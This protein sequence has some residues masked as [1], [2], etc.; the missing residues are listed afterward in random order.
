MYAYVSG[1]QK[2]NAFH[3]SEDLLERTVKFPTFVIRQRDIWLVLVCEKPPQMGQIDKTVSYGKIENGMRKKEDYTL[4]HDEFAK[5]NNKL[6]LLGNGGFGRVYKIKCATDKKRI[7]A[8]KV[9]NIQEVTHRYML[10]SPMK[11]SSK[12][13]T[14]ARNPEMRNELRQHIL[15]SLLNEVEIM[16][17]L[18]HRNIV[19]IFH[20]YMEGYISHE[21]D[22]IPSS[23]TPKHFNHTLPSPQ[24]LY[25]IMEYSAHGSLLKYIR[26]HPRQCLPELISAGITSQILEGLVYLA[27]LSIVH[28]DIKAANVLLFPHGVIKLC[29]F[30]L[31]FQWDDE[32][33]EDYDDYHHVS[34][35]NSNKQLQKIA[36]NGSAYWLAPEIILHRMATPK[37]DIWS[38]GATVIEMLTGFPPFSNRGPLSACHAV[39]SGAKIDYPR[40]ISEDCKLFLDSCFH[41]NPT[42]RSRA[43]T[44]KNQPWIKH[45]KTNILGFIEMNTDDDDGEGLDDIKLDVL[46]NTHNE[47]E[48]EKKQLYMLESFKEKDR[49]FEFSDADFDVT[50]LH[51]NDGMPGNKHSKLKRIDKLSHTE[52]GNLHIVNDDNE[53]KILKIN[54]LPALISTLQSSAPDNIRRAEQLLTL[55][56]KYLQ[57]HP[58]ELKRFCLSGSL[59]P[60]ST[61]RRDG[62]LG[63]DTIR[64][65][66]QLVWDGFQS[67]GREWL[68]AAGLETDP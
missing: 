48:I 53:F 1:S 28:G 36:T 63:E 56:E 60:L 37:S 20:Y 30:G 68:L 18:S 54:Y 61:A 49:D 41:Y 64:L 33:T 47:Q 3:V 45:V 26:S 6:Q 24:H 34:K 57:S 13:N 40:G 15:C 5:F 52:L 23:A 35:A 7:Y 38:L 19:S 65:V 58:E 50:T 10:E 17:G 21:R 44:L 32:N 46:P 51:M 59:V 8:M 66:Q 67:R 12:P 43:R 27:S 9:I 25:I 2:R 31:S 16:R 39:G 62:H 11:K 42:L 4:T 29:D 55:G 22:K 14:P